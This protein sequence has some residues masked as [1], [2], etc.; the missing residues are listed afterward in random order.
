MTTSNAPSSGTQVSWS[1]E[2][3]CALL[4]SRVRPR[5]KFKK[6]MGVA[7]TLKSDVTY[8]RDMRGV[9]ALLRPP[10]V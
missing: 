3:L 6:L 1:C 7:D 8:E 9:S 10:K 2:Y 5:Y 4:T